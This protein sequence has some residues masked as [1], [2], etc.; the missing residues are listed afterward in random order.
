MKSS[1]KAEVERNAKQI[2]TCIDTLIQ[3]NYETRLSKNEQFILRCL[4]SGMNC[5]Q[6]AILHRKIR[7]QR[8][9][10]I[11]AHLMKKISHCIEQTVNL[12]DF[13]FVMASY[14]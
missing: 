12:D 9:E 3:S 11:A 8:V 5:S 2:F 10:D 13:Q 7:V 4:L 6:I 1:S 14:L